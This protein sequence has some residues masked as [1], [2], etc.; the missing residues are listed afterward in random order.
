MRTL[1][2]LAAGT[3]LAAL[4]LSITDAQAAGAIPKDITAA[5]ADPARPDAD[6]Q[7]DADRTDAPAPRAIPAIEVEGAPFKPRFG[8]KS[9]PLSRLSCRIWRS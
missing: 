5:V 3:L 7:V 8:L 4:S 1:L 6:K 9:A 2:S